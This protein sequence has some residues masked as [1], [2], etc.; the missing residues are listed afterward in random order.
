[1]VIQWLRTCLLHAGDMGLIPWS[2][3][4]L[5]CREVTKLRCCVTTESVY[6]EPSSAIQRKSTHHNDNQHSQNK[7]DKASRPEFIWIKPDLH[8]GLS[9][10]KVDHLSQRRLT[11]QRHIQRKALC[12]FNSPYSVHDWCQSLYGEKILTEQKEGVNTGASVG[13]KYAPQRG[14][15]DHCKHTLPDSSAAFRL[16]WTHSC[17]NS[18]LCCPLRTSC[19]HHF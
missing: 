9:E 10:T 18:A 4:S 11:Y 15:W 1:M 3:P 13:S 17:S 6:L 2:K 16:V 8:C 12:G 7:I 5:T 14:T 19:L